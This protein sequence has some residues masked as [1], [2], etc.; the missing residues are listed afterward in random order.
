MNAR[1]VPSF[2]RYKT[3][4]LDEAMYGA[5]YLVRL[6]N[7]QGSFYRSI[8]NGGVDQKAEERKVSGEMKK[9]G[10][11]SRRIRR[12][13]TWCSRPATIVSMK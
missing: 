2:A 3:R 8:S 10:T 1:A 12:P 7:P 5:D 11:F 6:K 13:R 9:Y 4:A